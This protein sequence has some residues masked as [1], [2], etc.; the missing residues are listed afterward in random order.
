MICPVPPS[1]YSQAPAE[2]TFFTIGGTWF[3]QRLPGEHAVV[4]DA[5]LHVAA[6]E[7]G[8]QLTK[9]PHVASIPRVVAR[10]F[11]AARKMGG[12]L[13]KNQ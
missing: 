3:S 11:A 2:T 1:R 9:P 10:F 7:M 8:S 4:A 12:G 5:G 13:L 6:F